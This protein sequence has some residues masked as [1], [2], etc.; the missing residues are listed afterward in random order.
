MKCKLLLCLFALST[1]IIL[2]AQSFGWYKV[3][4]A[5]EYGRFEDISFIS[6]TKGW[7][8]QSDTIYM[9]NDGG[10]T[11]NIICDTILF[12]YIRSIEFIDDS[13]GFIGTLPMGLSTSN[14]FRTNDGGLSWHLID[15]LPATN[16]GI[17]GIAHYK[18]MVV[19]AGSVNSP[20]H[21]YI[22]HD[23]GITWAWHDLSSIASSLIDCF[24]FDSLHII[25]GGASTLANGSKAN[26]IYSNDGGL[27]WV[28][29]IKA[30]NPGTYSWKIF[31]QPNGIGVASV[32]NF[33]LGEL[34]T[35]VD[36]GNTWIHR[37]LNGTTVGNLGG[38]AVINDSVIFTG[39]QHN[40]GMAMSKDGGISWET[41]NLFTSIDRIHKLDSFQLIGSGNTIYKF[42]P[43][44]MLANIT[45]S[46]VVTH[47]F[48][49]YANNEAL[50]LTMNLFRRTKVMMEIFSAE[51][52]FI[53]QPINNFF[54]QG[55]H[56]LNFQINN[57]PQ[58]SYVVIIRTYEGHYGKKFIKNH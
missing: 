2:N 30:P 7:I 10:T 48:Q 36:S 52:K 19:A 54:T 32:E 1:T 15:S 21:L 41:G 23:R 3:A 25:V 14:L 53:S 45:S 51:G 13:V 28:E 42:H 12:G 46:P 16:G 27:T 44:T 5:P 50:K 55:E 31:F 18:D 11:W 49:L 17:C 8:A 35:T 4:G 47:E 33:I 57:L 38:I 43:D 9:T 37:F 24:V 34:F 29:K 6:A 56:N 22:S 40:H 20:A 58:G 26:I 39:D